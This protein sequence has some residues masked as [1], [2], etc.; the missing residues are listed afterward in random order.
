MWRGPRPGLLILGL[1]VCPARNLFSCASTDSITRFGSV[2]A[3]FEE[4]PFIVTQ[5]RT[6]LM[7]TNQATFSTSFPTQ[8]VADEHHLPPS[9]AIPDPPSGQKE[10]VVEVHNVEAHHKVYLNQQTSFWD[11]YNTQADAYDKD[12]VKSLALDLDT[13][14]IFVSASVWMIFQVD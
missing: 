4:F 10:Q 8:L 13:L 12:L 2:T 6:A 11:K 5:P 14:L 7:S 3:K 9:L 1:S